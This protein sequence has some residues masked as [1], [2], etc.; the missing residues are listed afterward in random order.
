MHINDAKSGKLPEFTHEQVNLEIKVQNFI[1][2]TIQIDI[3]SK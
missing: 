1:T 2:S 3:V